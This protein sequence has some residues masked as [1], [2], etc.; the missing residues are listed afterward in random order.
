MLIDNA[1]T[2][3]VHSFIRSGK[4]KSMLFLDGQENPWPAVIGLTI[5]IDVDPASTLNRE[6]IFGPILM[7]M[8]FKSEE[9]AL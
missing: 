3:S 5:F 4:T 7:V 1:H 2:D 9:Q 6:G 8:R